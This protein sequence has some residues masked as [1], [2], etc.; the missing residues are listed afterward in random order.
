MTKPWEYMSFDEIKQLNKKQIV[1]LPIG[2]IEA[3]GKHLPIATDSIITE[4]LTH[5]VSFKCQGIQGPLINF[6]PCET[7]IKFPGTITISEHTLGLLLKEIILSIIYHGFRKICIINGHGG[8]VTPLDKIITWS[9]HNYPDVTIMFANWYEMP[10]LI[11]LK[12]TVPSYKGDH[13]DRA[14]T[15]M[16]LVIAAHLVKIKKAIDDLPT[17][18]KKIELLEDYS[19]IMKYAVDGF[20]SKSKL[21]TAHKLYTSVTRDLL[22]LVH[23][24]FK[25]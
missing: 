6:G 2:T 4:N 1:F 8:N 13:A 24:F 17:W 22:E 16:M 23:V 25:T 12:Q 19:D 14:E 5:N 10:S 15:E 21:S 18:P 9:K 7:L 20:P 3:H 11:K